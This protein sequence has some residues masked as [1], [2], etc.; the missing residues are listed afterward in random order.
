MFFISDSVLGTKALSAET[1]CA[2]SFRLLDTDK[3]LLKFY[4]L[5]N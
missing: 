3:L 1:D 5:R 2:K 4:K